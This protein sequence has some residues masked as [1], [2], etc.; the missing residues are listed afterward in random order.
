MFD[1][2]AKVFLILLIMFTGVDPLTAGRLATEGQTYQQM[3]DKA[4][5]VVIATALANKDTNERN[6]LLK[7]IDVIGVETEFKTR[8]TLKG[9]REIRKFVLHHYREPDGQDTANG[10]AFVYI[11][12]G[13]HPDFLMFLIKEKDGRY[14]P[15]TGQT[16]PLLFSVLAL[17][18]AVISEGPEGW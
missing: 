9:S 13:R 14:A 1:M 7:D 6:K 4:D 2:P 5:L 10:P 15:V 3:F 8:V 11:P 16:D 12:P 18:S 17:K